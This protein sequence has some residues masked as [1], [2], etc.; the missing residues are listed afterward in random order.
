MS[1]QEESRKRLLE[2]LSEIRDFATTQREEADSAIDS[3]YTARK[4]SWTLSVVEKL[5]RALWDFEA[6]L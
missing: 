6:G 3:Q 1:E 5:D 4:L 2:A